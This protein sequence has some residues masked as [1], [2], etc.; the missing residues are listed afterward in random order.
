MDVDLRDLQIGDTVCY[1]DGSRAIVTA[2]FYNKSD[3]RVAFTTSACGFI[4]EN[5]R[6]PDGS[7]S[8]KNKDNHPWDVVEVI[9][10]PFSWEDVKRGM[11]FT[12]GSSHC[13]FVGNTLVDPDA[14]VGVTV[15]QEYRVYRKASVQ[16]L[17]EK[18]YKYWGLGQA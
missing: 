9:Q 10:K 1:R 16:R 14:F 3:E 17:P 4:F 6:S 2:V 8:R 7:Y 12:T 18:D 13:F 11:A 5:G 15:K